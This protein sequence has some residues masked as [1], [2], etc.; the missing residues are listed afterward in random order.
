MEGMIAGSPLGQEREAG[1]EREGISQP[2]ANIITLRQKPP[3]EWAGDRNMQKWV[4]DEGNLA[5][6][7]GFRAASAAA[8]I[9]KVRDALDLALIFSD[10][11]ETTAAGMFTTNRA[12]AAP[13]L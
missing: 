4:I 9:K 10:S 1:F 12:A 8:G 2:H 11:P 13:V 5:T 7:R 6:P 3:G